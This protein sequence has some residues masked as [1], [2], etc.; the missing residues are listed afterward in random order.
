MPCNQGK[1]DNIAAAEFT[2]HGQIMAREL[3]KSNATIGHGIDT[4]NRVWDRLF[5]DEILLQNQN[6]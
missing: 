6:K 4:I 1:I 2:F 3:Q 5:A